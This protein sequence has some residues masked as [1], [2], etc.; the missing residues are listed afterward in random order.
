MFTLKI[1]VEVFSRFVEA[2][3][4]ELRIHMDSE[5]FSCWIENQT[6][7]LYSSLYLSIFSVFPG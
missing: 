5:L 6:H 1:C 2:R 7:C 3:I 4:L